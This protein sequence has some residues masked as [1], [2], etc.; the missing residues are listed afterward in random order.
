MITPTT[1]RIPTTEMEV[2]SIR[3]DRELKQ[4][5]KALAGDQGYQALVREILWDYVLRHSGEKYTL[6]PADIQASFPA[7]AHQAQRCALTGQPIQPQDPML[8][9]WT[10]DGKFVALSPSSL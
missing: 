3:L 7:T 4:R 6:S 5:L 2:T 10:L 8:L 1:P 9:G